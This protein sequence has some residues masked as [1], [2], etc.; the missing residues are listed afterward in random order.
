MGDKV[1]KHVMQY[2]KKH[3][4]IDVIKVKKGKRIYR[5]LYD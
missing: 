2:K 4:S 1:N 3:F 5:R